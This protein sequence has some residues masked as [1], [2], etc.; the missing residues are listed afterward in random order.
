MSDHCQGGTCAPHASSSC[1]SASCR[2]ASTVELAGMRQVWLWPLSLPAGTWIRERG[3]AGTP[4]DWEEITPPPGADKGTRVLRRIDV[5]RLEADLFQGETSLIV[6]AVITQCQLTVTPDGEALF[7]VEADFGSR[8]ETRSLDRPDLSVEDPAGTHRRR[9]MTL[10]DA[11]LIT[12]HLR[13]MSPDEAP[14][15]ALLT[16]LDDGGRPLFG[17]DLADLADLTDDE[18]TLPPTDGRPLLAPLLGALLPMGLVEAGE[19]MP[20]LSLITLAGSLDEVCCQDWDALAAAGSGAGL[21]EP[22]LPPDFERPLD[23]RPRWP[24]LET[25]VRLRMAGSH[26]VVVGSGNGFEEIQVER[27]RD[28]L[29]PHAMAALRERGALRALA[30]NLQDALALLDTPRGTAAFPATL[31]DLQRQ[32]LL[33]RRAAQAL[34]P[35]TPRDVCEDRARWRQAL[36]LD[37]QSASLAAT[38][39]RARAYADASRQAAHLEAGGTL[40]VLLGAAMVVLGLLLFLGMNVLFT[41]GLLDPLVR[42]VHAF[43]VTRPGVSHIGL[44]HLYVHTSVALMV[45]SVGAWLGTKATARLLPEAPQLVGRMNRFLDGVAHAAAWTLCVLFLMVFLLTR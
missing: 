2:P 43:F 15:T 26:A 25:P 38:L 10:A 31:L 23:D 16:W 12:D 21:A 13:R 39:D 28:R 34:P 14:G 5:A 33:A 45:T 41:D 29:V 4:D 9:P 27:L 7:V 8:S 30:Q 40:T 1:D 20:T 6:R 24:G 18:E 32:A 42:R 36:G 11:R 22:P 19:P 44:V 37:L 35:A 17:P 3:R